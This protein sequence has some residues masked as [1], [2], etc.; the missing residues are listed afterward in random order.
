MKLEEKLI[1]AISKVPKLKQRI[2]ADAIDQ[3]N[4]A[5]SHREFIYRQKL[6][7]KLKRE[8]TNM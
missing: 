4:H 7:T 3:M 8:V 2:L 6:I 1:T 5:P